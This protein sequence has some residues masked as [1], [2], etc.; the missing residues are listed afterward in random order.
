[1]TE[2]STPATRSLSRSSSRSATVNQARPEGSARREASAKSS[3]IA[4]A[5]PRQNPR[6]LVTAPPRRLTNRYVPRSTRSTI[7]SCGF[8]IRLPDL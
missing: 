1:M 2:R 7:H 4:S 6:R 5:K 3:R 8:V